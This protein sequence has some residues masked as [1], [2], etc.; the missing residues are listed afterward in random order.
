MNNKL[1][2]LLKE[3]NRDDKLDFSIELLKYL[4]LEV[5]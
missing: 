1:R 3:N 2:Q 5:M 4:N